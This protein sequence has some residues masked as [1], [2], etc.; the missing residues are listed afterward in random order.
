M[1]HEQ[2]RE[3]FVILMED[4]A[5]NGCGLTVL[6]WRSPQQLT[7]N[8]LTQALPHPHGSFLSM[9]ALH[10]RTP[11]ALWPAA[12]LG[13]LSSHRVWGHWCLLGLTVSCLLGLT[14]SCLRPSYI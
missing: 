12:H 1:G 3:R 6:P 9:A 5:L 13:T 7:E 11:H 10:P 4:S 14:V 8:I 2:D